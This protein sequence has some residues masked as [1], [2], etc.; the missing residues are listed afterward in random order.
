M[1]YCAEEVVYKEATD[2][3][4][5]EIDSDLDWGGGDC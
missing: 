1:A 2:V 3:V 5:S 4:P